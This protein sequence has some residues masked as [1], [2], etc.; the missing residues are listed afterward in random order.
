MLEKY[1]ALQSNDLVAA[2]GLL[3]KKVKE[4]DYEECQRPGEHKDFFESL[5]GLALAFSSK[6]PDGMEGRESPAVLVALIWN[7]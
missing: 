5:D 4:F 6:A 2:A 7:S 3:I 1:P